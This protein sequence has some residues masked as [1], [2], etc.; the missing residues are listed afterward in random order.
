MGNLVNS[1]EDNIILAFKATELHIKGLSND[2]TDLLE[3]KRFELV[4]TLR[5]AKSEHAIV[6]T[7]T[8]QE[9]RIPFDKL[10]PVI[11][12][13]QSVHTLLQVVTYWLN[14]DE[15]RIDFPLWQ[16]NRNIQC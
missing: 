1:Q 10:L 15:Y 2:I 3:Q 8:E 16:D 13:K 14:D 6:F 7:A 12:E 5:N 11:F 9:E 4:G